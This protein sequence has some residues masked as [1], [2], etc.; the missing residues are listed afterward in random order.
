MKRPILVLCLLLFCLA[1]VPLFAENK[2]NPIDTVGLPD[3]WVDESMSQQWVVRDENLPANFCSVQEGGVT[4]GIRKIVRFTVTTPN[5]GDADI[6][7]GDP[8]EHIAANDGLFEFAS[9]HN[10]Y[11][12]QHY[13]LYEL[14]DPR[15][16]FVWKAAKRGFCMLDTDPVPTSQGNEQPR[17][18][19]F[20]SCGLVGIPAIKG[21][22]TA[23]PTHIGSS[24]EDSIS[25]ST[26]ATAKPPF[27]QAII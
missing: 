1:A 13:A 8:N 24:S 23:G 12:F 16:G 6:Y 10:H 18:A 17:S 22:A 11:H 26:A 21:S 27:H 7:I 19:I 15:T 2:N 3:L 14:V 25:S 5:T 20:R 9:C 4:P